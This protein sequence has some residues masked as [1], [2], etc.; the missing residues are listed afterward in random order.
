MQATA[1]PDVLQAS[2]ENLQVL[3]CACKKASEHSMYLRAILLQIRARSLEHKA[4]CGQDNLDPRPHLAALLTIAEEALPVSAHMLECLLPEDPPFLAVGPLHRKH[5]ALLN[6]CGLLHCKYAET[7]IKLSGYDLSKQRPVFPTVYGTNASAVECFLDSTHT[8]ALHE[9]VAAG[10][11]NLGHSDLALLYAQEAATLLRGHSGTA[12]AQLVLACMHAAL[13]QE[14]I[15]RPAQR[16]GNLY[17]YADVE[18]SSSMAQ[19]MEASY[20][21]CGADPGSPRMLAQQASN[22]GVSKAMQ[23]QVLGQAG[24]AASQDAQSHLLD[25][26]AAATAAVHASALAHDWCTASQAACVLARLHSAQP[27]KAAHA[28]CLLRA[29]GAAKHLLAVLGASAPRE[30]P[31][32]VQAASIPGPCA[33]NSTGYGKLQAAVLGAVQLEN[34]H[35]VLTAAMKYLPTHVRVLTMEVDQAGLVHA[36]V[37]AWECSQ[38]D[39]SSERELKAS[40]H[41]AKLDQHALNSLKEKLSSWETHLSCAPSTSTTASDVVENSSLVDGKHSPGVDFHASD[42]RSQW[43]EILLE[44]DQLLGPFCGAIAQAAA[45]VAKPVMPEAAVKGKQQKGKSAEPVERKS[46]VVL[47]IAEE[48][49]WL[50]LE[51]A[52]AL[53]DAS[54]IC[55]E[56]S[57]F[58]LA[59]RAEAGTGCTNVPLS[60]AVHLHS[61]GIEEELEV[62]ILNQFGAQWMGETLSPQNLHGIGHQVKALQTAPM[63]LFIS[64]QRMEEAITLSALSTANLSAVKL[65]FI[66]DR[67]R[68]PGA[69]T[70]VQQKRSPNNDKAQTLHQQGGLG[71][72]L[73]ARGVQCCLIAQFPCTA[74]SALQACAEL[75]VAAKAG[76]TIAEAVQHARATA[77]ASDVA[78]LDKWLARGVL[79]YGLPY[80][81]VEAGPMASD[82]KRR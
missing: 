65:A 60:K 69:P 11:D 12:Q 76:K 56:L 6:A 51:S 15:D 39:S 67:I 82:G 44:L 70:Q 13:W 59:M 50:P 41:C 80:V 38:S 35:E 10:A 37:L 49:A 28:V 3:S 62:Q 75:L 73:L 68:I 9:M 14:F 31:E 19:H 21:A 17:T 43:E 46:A 53:R 72:L 16:V 61:V 40:A 54:C 79:V 58:A 1:N 7:D 52:A 8:A 18:L 4:R 42:I 25:A 66:L 63:L 74:A 24:V 26:D 45:P 22:N 77:A 81:G 32:H 47:C 2:A 34:S 29:C 30:H 5:A 71:S 36:A 27:I 64:S 33:D 23:H 57:V 48:L 55:R 78:D 20:E